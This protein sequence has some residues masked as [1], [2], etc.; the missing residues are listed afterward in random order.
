M[1]WIL[2]PFEKALSSLEEVLRLP[3]DPIIRDSAIQRFEYTYE[4]AFKFM[5]RFLKEA[6]A[7]TAGIEENGFKDILRAAA[8]AGMVEDVERWFSYRGARNMTSHTYDEKKAAQVFGLLPAF[9]RDARS[10]LEALQRR[11]RE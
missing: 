8:A 5:K 1:A 9:A 2:T 3:V 4:L 11:N 7:S 10:L 6:A